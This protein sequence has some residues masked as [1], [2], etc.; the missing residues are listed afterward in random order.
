MFVKCFE[1]ETGQI[2]A[3]LDC[4]SSDVSYGGKGCAEEAL[5]ALNSPSFR[6]QAS[7]RLIWSKPGIRDNDN[8]NRDL[9]PLPISP[10]PAC[11]S[12]R[13]DG[14]VGYGPAL[15]GSIASCQ[16]LGQSCVARRAGTF[17]DE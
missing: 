14:M 9:S 5:E 7:H 6:C 10:G 17:C 8:C 16:A 3:N 1:V 2:G 15:V 4:K 12:T 13:R 11:S